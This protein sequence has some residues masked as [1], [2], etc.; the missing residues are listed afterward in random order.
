MVCQISSATRRHRVRAPGASGQTRG[1]L[2]ENTKVAVSDAVKPCVARVGG[3][4]P[5][6]AP[7]PRRAPDV[8]PCH[9]APPR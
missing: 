9:A 3:V 7:Q 1:C 2:S 4:A 5:V 6:R 8:G